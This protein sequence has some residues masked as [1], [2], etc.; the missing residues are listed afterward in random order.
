ML[1]EK[2][3]GNALVSDR[4]TRDSPFPIV[5]GSSD[6]SEFAAKKVVT[7]DESEQSRASLCSLGVDV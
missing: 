6:S 7:A 4:G 3:E 2:E 5:E 1:H